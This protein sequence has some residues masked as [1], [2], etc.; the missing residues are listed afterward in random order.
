MI[1]G[2]HD[3]EFREP[4]MQLFEMFRQGE[5]TMLLSGITLDEL[6][7][8]PPP[9]RK[10]NSSVPAEHTELLVVSREARELADAYIAGEAMGGANRTDALHIALAT[11]AKADLL[12]SWNFRHMVNWQRIRACNEVNR[13]NGHPAID[14][15]TPEEI[16]HD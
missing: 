6:A 1:G 15:R 9:V 2:C 4:S 7:D 14:I 8:A 10:A 11:L 13:Q 12:V 3:D 16:V 5:A